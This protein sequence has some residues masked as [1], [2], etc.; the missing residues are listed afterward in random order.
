MRIPRRCDHCGGP[1][2]SKNC[3]RPEGV[4]AR[5]GKTVP[6]GLGFGDRHGAI[7]PRRSSD[8]RQQERIDAVL[9]EIRAKKPKSRRPK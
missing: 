3:N 5:K 9:A 8:N 7:S 4:K 2:I 1:H 6:P